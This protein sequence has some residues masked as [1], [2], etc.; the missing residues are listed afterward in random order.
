MSY[1]IGYG[2]KIVEFP[3]V[4]KDRLAHELLKIVSEKIGG[5]R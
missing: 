4:G 3:S 1:S 2:G 5:V